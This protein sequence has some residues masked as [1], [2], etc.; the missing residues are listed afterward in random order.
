VLAHA[1]PSLRPS[2]TTTLDT[3]DFG[4]VPQGGTGPLTETVYNRG[5]STLQAR[6]RFT[7]AYVAGTTRFSAP[8]P[9]GPLFGASAPVVVSFDATG[10]APDQEFTAELRLG[11]ADEPL[12]GALA[13]DTLRVRLHA[14][15]ATNG[16]VTD[17][18]T[19]LRFAPPAPNP[20]R[21][22]TRFA[23]DLPQPAMVSL[24]IYDPSGRRVAQLA[25][26]EWPAGRHQLAWQPVREDGST[27][28]AGL[29]FAS[30]RTPG[31]ERVARI[32]VLP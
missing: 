10:A 29:Y 4:T 16:G 19:A 5:F 6:M 3:L 2:A 9:P 7:A 1:V 30:F 21:S 27:L 12:P 25:Q 32:I 11:T 31:M 20:L 24:A 22:T 14:H 8:P 17:T 13:G 28:P 23:F 15:I 26:G 18:P